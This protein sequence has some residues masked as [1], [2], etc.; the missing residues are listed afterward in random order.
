LLELLEHWEEVCQRRT[1]WERG[2]GL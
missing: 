1:D 2:C